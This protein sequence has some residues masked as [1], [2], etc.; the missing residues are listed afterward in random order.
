MGGRRA[1]EGDEYDTKN[2]TH[3]HKDS[4]MK[5]I[6]LCVPWRSVL[7]IVTDLQKAEGCVMAFRGQCDM[8]VTAK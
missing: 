6:K 8:G 3:M 1:K 7:C 4:V 2:F 5:P